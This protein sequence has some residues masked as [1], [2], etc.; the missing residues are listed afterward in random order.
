[1]L[2]AAIAKRAGVG[3]QD[4][5]VLCVLFNTDKDASVAVEVFL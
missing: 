3:T 4:V 1:M 2:Q 5:E